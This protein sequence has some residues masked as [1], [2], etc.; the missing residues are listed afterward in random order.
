MYDH[1]GGQP[2]GTVGA[3]GSGVNVADVQALERAPR[4]AQR[5]AEAALGLL[6]SLRALQLERLHT[7]WRDFSNDFGQDLRAQHDADH[8]HA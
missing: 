1:G 4:T 6:G 8:H 3:G 7:R 5:M 2:A